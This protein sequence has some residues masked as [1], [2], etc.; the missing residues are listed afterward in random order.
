MWE[1]VGLTSAEGAAY[2]ALLRSRQPDAQMLADD[3]QLTRGQAARLL[4]RLVEVGL[5]TRLPGRRARF[6]PAPPDTL[7]ATLIEDRQRELQSLRAHAEKLAE[8]CKQQEHAQ[9]HP[10]ELVEVVEGAANVQSAFLRLQ[11]SARAQIRGFDRPPYLDNPVGGNPEQNR[12]QEDRGI[13]YRVVYD[14][15]AV[16][17]PGRMADIWRSI[18]RGERARVSGRVPMKMVLCDDTLALIPVTTEGYAA[19]AAYVVHPSSLLDAVSELFEAVWD[20]AV[21]LNRPGDER[22]PDGSLPPEDA[23]LIGL[24]AAGA[25]DESIARAQGWSVRTVHRHVHRLM[26]LVGAQTRFQIG[27]EAARRGWV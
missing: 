10:A 18:Q 24:L 22:L 4:G 12:Q 25:T 5:A 23:D 9:Q 8:L 20:R 1:S 2:E 6:A 27:L 3:L 13:L 19:D 7:T 16:E 11:R 15:T 14:R 26:T 17:I 21:P